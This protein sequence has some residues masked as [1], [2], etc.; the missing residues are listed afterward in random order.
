MIINI[1]KIK[2]KRKHTNKATLWFLSGEALC[3][4]NRQKHWQILYVLPCKDEE[5]LLQ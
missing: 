3:D 4:Q 5:M 2:K 1:K